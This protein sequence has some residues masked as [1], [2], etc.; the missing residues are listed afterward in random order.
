[1]HTKGQDFASPLHSE[2][3]SDFHGTRE[4][5][6]EMNHRTELL[7]VIVTEKKNT[8][9]SGMAEWSTLGRDSNYKCSFTS[10]ALRNKTV[11][12][13][14]MKHETT[15][16]RNDGEVVSDEKVADSYIPH[17]GFTTSPK[18]SSLSGELNEKSS[19]ARQKSMNHS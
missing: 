19:A 11:G 7:R 16:L 5:V 9:A 12:S 8:R 14:G 15:A 4:A 6:P 3:K 13:C 18:R 2:E 1:M 10:G 17:G